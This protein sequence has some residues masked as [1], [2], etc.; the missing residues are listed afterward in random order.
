MRAVAKSKLLEFSRKHSDFLKGW[1]LNCFNIKGYNYRLIAGVHWGS[2]VYV[3]ELLTH[4][5]YTKKYVKGV[6]K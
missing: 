4:A 5:E 6:N 3:K 1:D 2:A